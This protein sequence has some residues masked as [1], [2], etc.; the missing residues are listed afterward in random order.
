MFMYILSVEGYGQ[1]HPARPCSHDFMENFG[2]GLCAEGAHAATVRLHRGSAGSDGAGD[3]L[4][5]DPGTSEKELEGSLSDLRGPDA[6]CLP[7]L[8][9]GGRRISALRPLETSVFELPGAAPG[10]CASA[11]PGPDFALRAYVLQLIGPVHPEPPGSRKSLLIK[12]Q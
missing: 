10:S 9:A 5:L 4:A 11:A 8:P 6:G 3:P 1:I 2:S 12:N 7:G